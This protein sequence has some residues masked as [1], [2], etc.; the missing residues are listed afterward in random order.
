VPLVIRFSACS[1]GG[2]K[3]AKPARLGAAPDL[4]ALAGLDD[5]SFE[6]QLETPNAASN[7]KAITVHASRSGV[8]NFILLISLFTSFYQ[9]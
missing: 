6:L 5:G 1:T 4:L 8:Q 3:V 7:P 9:T 2:D